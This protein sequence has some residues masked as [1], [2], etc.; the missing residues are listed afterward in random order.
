L[1]S[2]LSLDSRLIPGPVELI[3][4]FDFRQHD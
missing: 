1:C 4:V 2:L 3:G